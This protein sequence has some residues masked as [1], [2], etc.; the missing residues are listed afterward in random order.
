[1]NSKLDF[2]DTIKAKLLGEVPEVKTFRLFNNQFEKEK[3]EKAFPFPAVMLEFLDMPYITKAEGMQQTEFLFTLHVGFAS[4][5]TEDRDIFILVQ[6]ITQCLQGF[7][8]EDLFSSLVRTRE[9]QDSNY[10]AVQVWQLQFTTVL[11]DNSGHK[12]RRL[13]LMADG[14]DELEIGKT[15]NENPPALQ[16]IVVIAQEIP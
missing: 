1:M 16:P 5:K 13:V 15:Q 6:K 12:R 8:F 14:I 11:F 3:V 10:D 9:T 2:F 7:A 4:L